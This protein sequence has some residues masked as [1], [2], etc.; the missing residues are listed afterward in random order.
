MNNELSKSEKSIINSLSQF[1]DD[2]FY[3][4]EYLNYK[5]K[6]NMSLK[7]LIPVIEKKFN[8]P[9][10]S[11]LIKKIPF[12]IVLN[13]ILESSILMRSDVDSYE[14]RFKMIL[15]ENTRK[16]TCVKH[17]II[18][19]VLYDAFCE[20]ICPMLNNLKEF[21][22]QLISR[23]D[24]YINFEQKYRAIKEGTL[25]SYNIYLALLSIVNGFK[26]FDTKNKY[27]FFYQPSYDSSLNFYDNLVELFVGNFSKDTKI[28]ISFKLVDHGFLEDFSQRASNKF[29]YNIGFVIE[30]FLKYFDKVYIA[31][32]S[33]LAKLRLNSTV[34]D[35]TIQNIIINNNNKII[36]DDTLDDF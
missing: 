25:E 6:Y 28:V 7:E 10:A 19:N 31:D 30:S 27:V 16:F 13:D 23:C 4:Q 8:E 21:H 20:I 35:K 34:K 26:E 29:V 1:D 2:S 22:K 11:E 14:T 5:F 32:Y 15:H 17:M 36:L 24:K 12:I 3:M 9:L 18:D 33:K